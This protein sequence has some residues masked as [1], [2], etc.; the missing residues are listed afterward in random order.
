MTKRSQYLKR[1]RLKYNSSPLRL[2]TGD[3]TT[4]V[5]ADPASSAALTSRR[6]TINSNTTGYESVSVSAVDGSA[7]STSVA[8]G[9]AT[10]AGSGQGKTTKSTV[11]DLDFVSRYEAEIASPQRIKEY[12]NIATQHKESLL[13]ETTVLRSQFDSQLTVAEGMEHNIEGVSSMLSEFLQIIETQTDQILDIR[14]VSKEATSSVTKTSDELDLTITRNQSYQTNMVVMI[15]GL[16][17]LLL[18]LDFITP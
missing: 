14:D 11:L 12:A 9:A 7:V 1:Q 17:F 5:E 18:V 2:L 10:G 3:A 13:K 8:S 16:A 4:G 15:V 6:T